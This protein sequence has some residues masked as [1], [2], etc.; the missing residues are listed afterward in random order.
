[1]KSA[2]GGDYV[3][4]IEQGRKNLGGL[5]RARSGRKPDLRGLRRLITPLRAISQKTSEVLRGHVPGG[6]QTSEVY[7]GS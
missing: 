6:N 5:T 3:G 2:E 4:L 1:M 7:A